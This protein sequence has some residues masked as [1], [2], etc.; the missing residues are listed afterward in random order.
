LLKQ[1]TYCVLLDYEHPIVT[2]AKNND[3]L[4]PNKFGFYS[5][6]VHMSIQI[7]EL[8]YSEDI[9]INR[10]L[11]ESRY[12]GLKELYYRWCAVKGYKPN[13]NEGWFKS[14]RFTRYLEERKWCEAKYAIMADFISD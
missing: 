4:F 13:D 2:I 10:K 11:I 12:K 14:K 9:A 6:S 1:D 5:N 8:H 3:A 7:Y